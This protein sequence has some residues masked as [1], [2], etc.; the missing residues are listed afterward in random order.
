MTDKEITVLDTYFRLGNFTIKPEHVLALH[1]NATKSM[2][3]YTTLRDTPIT[4]IYDEDLEKATLLLALARENETYY[5]LQ[6]SKT[7]ATDD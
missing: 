2:Q 7:N 5:N 4:V 6:V 1:Q 3:I